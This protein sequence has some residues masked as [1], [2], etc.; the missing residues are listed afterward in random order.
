[1]KFSEFR[2]LC[3]ERKELKTLME[4]DKPISNDR[5]NYLQKVL[6]NKDFGRSFEDYFHVDYYM[7]RQLMLDFFKQNN[8]DGKLIFDSSFLC[9]LINKNSNSQKYYYLCL[10]FY[11]MVDLKPLYEQYCGEHLD[12]DDFIKYYPTVADV[13]WEAVRIQM[14]DFDYRSINTINKHIRKT[15]EKSSF[16]KTKL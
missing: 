11:R 5:F 7:F 1:M 13:L 16:C 14:H 8:I 12:F 4:N 15:I 9:V 6:R 3:E 10:D 2:K